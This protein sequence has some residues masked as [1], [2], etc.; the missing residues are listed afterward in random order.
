M[1]VKSIDLIGT[2]LPL[3]QVS[4]VIKVL[5]IGDLELLVLIDMVAAGLCFLGRVC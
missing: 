1:L 4:A 5:R 3:A 2:P